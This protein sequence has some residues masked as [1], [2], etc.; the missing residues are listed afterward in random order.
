MI[1]Q[2]LLESWFPRLLLNLSKRDWWGRCSLY[3]DFRC[4]SKDWHMGCANFTVRIPPEN[5]I[6]SHASA[7]ITNKP[8]PTSLEILSSKCFE[9][10]YER[11]SKEIWFG[12]VISNFRVQ[13]RQVSPLLTKKYYSMWSLNH[14]WHPILCL[15]PFLMKHMYN[16]LSKRHV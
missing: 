9:I 14:R 4:R 6:A 2:F 7:L 1:I 8:P 5:V 15:C 3:T 13:F 16:L 10:E 12:Q 11:I